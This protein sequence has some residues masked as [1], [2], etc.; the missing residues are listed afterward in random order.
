MHLSSLE[1]SQAALAAIK[2]LQGSFAIRHIGGVR[3]YLARHTRMSHEDV[4]WR[5]RFGRLHWSVTK[6][7]LERI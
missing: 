4:F 2:G 3:G 6:S 5:L 7:A 1:A